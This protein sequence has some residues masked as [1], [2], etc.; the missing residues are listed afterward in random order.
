MP[1]AVSKKTQDEWIEGQAQGLVQACAGMTL[2][3]A[4]PAGLIE[5]GVGLICG[6]FF[7]AVGAGLVASNVAA[8]VTVSTV[9]ASGM[10][11]IRKAAETMSFA[12]DKTEAVPND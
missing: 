2:I 7:Q 9:W 6:T 4:V 3:V 8:L 1:K 11:K 5:L 12:D 10:R